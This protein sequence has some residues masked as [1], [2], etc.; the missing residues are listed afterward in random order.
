MLMHLHMNFFECISNTKYTLYYVCGLH[1]HLFMFFGVVMLLH[2]IWVRL[3]YSMSSWHHQTMLYPHLLV[4][5]QRQRW[6][7]CSRLLG[8][9]H[10]ILPF[11]DVKAKECIEHISGK[12]VEEREDNKGNIK[13][14][15]HGSTLTTFSVFIT[16]WRM[17]CLSN[18]L[19]YFHLC[20]KTLVSKNFIM[21]ISIHLSYLHD[22]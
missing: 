22:L 12:E 2:R 1:M 7:H 13:A 21:P 6:S 19:M 4:V 17:I 18:F 15:M 16:L 9:D 10:C 20:S 14:S 5:A 11:V 8:Y 3:P